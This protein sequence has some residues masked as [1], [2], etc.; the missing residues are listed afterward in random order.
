MTVST[1]IRWPIAAATPP[2]APLRAAIARVVFEH[3]VR[4]VPVRVTCPDGREVTRT[5]TR[6]YTF[7]RILDYSDLQVDGDSSSPYIVSFHASRALADRR[8]SD[9]PRI[10]TW[11][12]VPVEIV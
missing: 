2:R 7:A 6:A 1:A 8:D 11:T 12:V 3:A 4:R 5:S 9:R 10:T